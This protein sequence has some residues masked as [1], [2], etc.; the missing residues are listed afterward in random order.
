VA[1]TGKKFES[2]RLSFD[3]LAGHYR[4]ME[5]VLAGDLLQRARTR[6]L[7][8]VQKPQQVLLAGEGPGR[9]LAACV[10]ALPQSHFTVVDQSA[11]M[12]AQARRGGSAGLGK[13]PVEF[14]QA[15]VRERL[16][17]R[18][19]F[20]LIITHFFLDC[21]N[22]EELAT[23][24]A[25]LAAAAAVRAEWLITDF[26]VP[27][28]GWRRMRARLVLWLAYGFFRQATD[29]SA[30]VITPPD[31]LLGA[32]GFNLRRREMFNYGLLHADLW[33]RA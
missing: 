25:N 20:D 27:P 19:N 4:W 14:R 10:A 9:M 7:S 18:G 28:R 5:P 12:L 21:F 24:I 22:P 15:D 26:Q 33:T 8:E 6:W 13:V 30:R 31:S 3:R 17:E 1:Q 2:T 29:I 16:P 11:A 32:A 23:V